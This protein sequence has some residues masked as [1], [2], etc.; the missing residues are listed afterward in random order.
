MLTK[1]GLLITLIVGLLLVSGLF[2]TYQVY[3]QCGGGCGGCGGD[4]S[5]KDDTSEP[6]KKDQDKTEYEM[7]SIVTGEALSPDQMLKQA[8]A[9][10]ARLE[11]VKNDKTQ[12]SQCQKEMMMLSYQMIRSAQEMVAKC[13][14]M[15]KDES[16]DIKKIADL[17]NQANDL[18]K[19]SLEMIPQGCIMMSANNK[20]TSSKPKEQY[21]CPMGCVSPVDKP[22]RCPK[23]GMNLKKK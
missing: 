1:K 13:S 7:K 2:V 18:L 9:L 19:K 17:T 5:K 8:D 6:G 21:A 3:A 16:P 11:K 4:N 15:L 12:K 23:C 14:E 22:G 20:D 10:E